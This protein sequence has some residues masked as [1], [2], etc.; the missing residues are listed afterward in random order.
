MAHLPKGNTPMFFGWRVVAGAFAAMMLVTGFYTYS[1]TLLVSPLREEFDA[2]LQQVM[3]SM[4]LATLS[5][6]VM[7]PL[8]GM[9]IDRL[10]LRHLMAAGL[11]I[12]GGGFWWLAQAQSI[13]VFN[14][15]FA[16]TL[17]GG[18]ALANTMTGGAVVSRWFLQN[19]GR[20]MGIA[21]IGTSVGGVLIPALTSFWIARHGWRDALENL[22]LL[23]LLLIV[24]FVWVNI[25]G[26]PADLGLHPDGVTRPIRIPAGATVPAMGI[27]DIVK[28]RSFWYIGLSVS[29]LVAVFSPMVANLSPYATQL[30]A[31]EAQAS[32]LVICLAIAGLIGK[33]I[34]GFAADKISLKWGL[35]TAQAL[36]ALAFLLLATQPPYA[37]M[38]LAAV[39]LG[40]ATGGLLP[41][42]NGMTATAFGVDS[43]GR[44]MGA[45]G[46][47]VTVLVTPAYALVGRLHDS[48][49]T[50][51]FAL[52]L[53]TAILVLAALLLVPL[54]LRG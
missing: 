33:L 15:I 6:L 38:L 42:W 8:A 12:V 13:L 37:L 24:P 49:G 14:L 27:G 4:T 25:R 3:Y 31:S 23:T 44:A 54:K 32:A 52:L 28:Q 29:L 36:V 26:K 1:F 10:D 45:M 47:L 5:G 9:L 53:F 16:L 30:G 40:L 2:S 35:W 46:P 19:R 7:A 18:N 39:M 22:S 41:V 43:Y 50:Y 20:A 51:E 48:T 11:L 17:G 21:T 34:F